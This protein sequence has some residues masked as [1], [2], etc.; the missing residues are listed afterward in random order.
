MIGWTIIPASMFEALPERPSAVDVCVE[1]LRRA[2]VRGELQP[3]ERLPPERTL[4]VSLGVNRTTLRAALREVAQTGLLSV[5]Q[6]SGYTVRDFRAEGGIELV[7]ALV[8]LARERGQMRSTCAELLRARRWLAGA[9]FER[10]A[11][12]PPGEAALQAVQRAV[13]TL[14]ASVGGS[15]PELAEADL[16]VIR[17]WVTAAGSDVLGVLV[18]HVGRLL[19]ELPELAGAI[20]A[21]P[22]QNVAIWRLLLQ[23]ARSGQPLAPLPWLQALSARDEATLARLEA[24]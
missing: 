18:G 4:A 22:E 8:E 24:P 11:A 15:L 7:P 5:R 12:E 17:A 16:G 13:D 1:V 19:A 2:I 6:G 14:E 20:Y 10:L 21:E 9:L 3:G 23:A